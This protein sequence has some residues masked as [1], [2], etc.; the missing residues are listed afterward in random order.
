MAQMDTCEDLSFNPKHSR[1]NANMVT[2]TNP[3]VEEAD[4]GGS[5]GLTDQLVWLNLAG[6]R[7]CKNTSQNRRWRTIEVDIICQSLASAR[8]HT[9]THTHTLNNNNNNNKQ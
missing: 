9:S 3:I 4:T 2:H 7:F 8:A 5:F 1:K 6:S